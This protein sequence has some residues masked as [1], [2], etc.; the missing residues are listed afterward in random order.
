M[1]NTVTITKILDGARSAV[2]HIFIKSDGASGELTDQVLIDPAADLDPI[3]GARPSLTIEQLWYD[4]SGFDARLEFDYL[5]DDTAAWTLSG[6]N[7]VHMD[8]CHFG[9]LKDRSSVLDGTGK[10]MLTTNG[11]TAAGDNGTI[12]IKVQKD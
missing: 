7:G 9:G 2:F 11:L 5:V 10:L 12:I 4:L 6:G 8:F 1:A 3:L